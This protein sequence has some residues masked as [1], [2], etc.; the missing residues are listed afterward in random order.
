MKPENYYRWDAQVRDYE[1]DIQG[2]VNHAIY[3]HY[4][5]QARNDFARNVG[6]DHIDYHHQGYDFVITAMELEFHR[7]L[8]A[9]MQ[10]YVT[11]TMT[12][13]DEKRMHFSQEIKR[14]EDDKV[15]V[16]AMVHLAC[17]D[18]KI[19]KACMPESLKV[20]FDSLLS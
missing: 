20:I 18:N 12:G 16:K 4:I 8:F 14:K 3:V 13:Y 9:K 11:V 15:I 10:F 6:I 2:V 5:E 17:I 1:L 19:R 7:P